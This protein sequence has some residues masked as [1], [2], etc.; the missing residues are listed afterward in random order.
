MRCVPPYEIYTNNQRDNLEYENVQLRDLLKQCISV[1]ERY[2]ENL[3]R[4]G[5]TGKPETELLGEITKILS[6]SKS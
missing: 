6:H 5:W 4:L 1:I 2:H 3:H